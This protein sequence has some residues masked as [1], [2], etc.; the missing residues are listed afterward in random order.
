MSC[1]GTYRVG[2]SNG[3]ELPWSSLPG[4]PACAC[5]CACTRICAC[6]STCTCASVPSLDY[7]LR[8]PRILGPGCW[9]ATRPSNNW[10]PPNAGHFV[11]PYPDH[12]TTRPPR[13]HRTP[14]PGKPSG[15]MAIFLA[16]WQ[17]EWQ[18]DLR[19][20]SEMTPTSSRPSPAPFCGLKR[21][22]VLPPYYFRHRT[23]AKCRNV[24]GRGTARRS[25][26]R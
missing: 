11:I 26:P 6:A 7:C 8:C 12:L 20:R 2:P 5:A 21:Q 4:E 14:V 23:R 16:A 1:P 24:Y 25:T 15:N 17:Q 10:H 3:H 18:Q 19:H 9:E 22:D 13:P